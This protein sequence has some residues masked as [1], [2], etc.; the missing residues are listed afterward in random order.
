MPIGGLE[1]EQ[2]DQFQTMSLAGD[3]NIEEMKNFLDNLISFENEGI[4]EAEKSDLV[5][6]KLLRNLK[7]HEQA[8]ILVK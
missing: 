6:Q 8:M 4:Q 7:V 1:P 5:I 3:F 2:E